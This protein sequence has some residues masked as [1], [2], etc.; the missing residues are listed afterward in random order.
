M[1]VLL[2]SSYW[3]SKEYSFKVLKCCL[4]HYIEWPHLFFTMYCKCDSL[5]LQ[6]F[7][8]C[9]TCVKCSTFVIAVKLLGSQSYVFII[10]FLYRLCTLFPNWTFFQFIFKYNS[11]LSWLRGTELAHTFVTINPSFLS[12]HIFFDLMRKM[13]S[14]LEHREDVLEH[15]KPLRQSNYSR[16]SAYSQRFWRC[17]V[18][19]LMYV[20]VWR[21]V[22]CCP[23]SSCPSLY[24]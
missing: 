10:C 14:C 7:L 19:I 11:I 13:Q 2:C 22:G 5:C 3:P 17:S 12:S 15:L 16:R 23:K 6:F 4:L 9:R 21:G 8:V 18:C 20:T 24:K 1:E